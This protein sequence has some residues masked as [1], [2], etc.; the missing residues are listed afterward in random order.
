MV[1]KRKLDENTLVNVVNNTNGVLYYKSP[2]TQ[3]D[4]RFENYED[5]D[6]MELHELR[7]MSASFKRYF[8]DNW[9]RILDDD[10]IEYLRLGRYFEKTMTS[11]ELDQMLDKSVDELKEFLDKSSSNVK[12]LILAKARERYEQGTLTNIHIIEMLKEKF[13]AEIDIT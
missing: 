3:R 5:E 11:E 13:G 9:I 2:R 12:S 8:E 10:V 7:T 6:V 1:T 4:W